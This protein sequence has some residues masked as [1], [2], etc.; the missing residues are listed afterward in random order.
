MLGPTARQA[1]KRAG[2]PEPIRKFC[3]KGSRIIAV[4]L[5][6]KDPR[7]KTIKFCIMSVHMPHCG[8]NY[9]DN[10]FLQCL[11]CIEDIL[12]SLDKN[13]VPLIFGDFNARI[14]TRQEYSF[15]AATP[16]LGKFG[17]TETNDRGMLL[18]TSTTF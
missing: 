11:Q 12:K 1:Y 15:A 13:T 8:K 17:N 7:N 3:A 9:T 16:L 4:N 5:S 2:S 6:F 14:G 18:F 10:D